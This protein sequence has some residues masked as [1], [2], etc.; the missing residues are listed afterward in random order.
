MA[1]A[2]PDPL[3]AD[4]FL[5]ARLKLRHLQLF[6]ALDEQRNLH[7]AAAVL[8][9]AQPA[10]S[11]LLAELEQGLGRKLFERLPRGLTPNPS[12]EVLVRR[13]RMILSELAGAR[14]EMSALGTGESGA[15]W[16]GAVDAPAS[17][18]LV[19]V[20]DAMQRRH[21]G[22]QIHVH[23][24]TSDILTRGILDGTLDFALA[25]IVAG[26]PA[27][28]FYYREIEEER[29]S[30]IC[31]SGHRLAGR[32]RVKLEDLDGQHWV[33]QPRGTLLRRRVEALFLSGGLRAPSSVV[34]TSSIIVTLA[35]VAGTDT[36]SVLSTEVAAQYAGR[37]QI[38]TLRFDRPVT[39]E[40]YGLIL[41]RK[42]LLS[43]AARLMVAAVDKA[44]GWT[45]PTLAD[46]SLAYPARGAA[47]GAPTPLPA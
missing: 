21:P 12:G 8:G 43:P 24:A 33:L 39:V 22:M 46:P 27:E 15:V 23:S 29:L 32:G 28:A 11:K 25:R 13:A 1:H 44:V 26:V 20:I 10:A 47:A 37:G 16:V 17:G 4:W 7:R 14:E 35:L 19:T 36:L 41:S 5:R 40:P 18:L 2:P 38:R 34:S 3:P 6:V 42:R 31:R 45:R 9:I 30:F